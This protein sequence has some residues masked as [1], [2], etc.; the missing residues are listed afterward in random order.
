MMKLKHLLGAVAGT[1]LLASCGGMAGVPGTGAGVSPSS[2]PPVAT[3][4][5]NGSDIMITE[6]SH[7]VAASIGKRIVVFLRARPGMTNWSNISSSDVRVLAPAV[8][9]VMVPHGV[10]AAAFTAVGAGAALITASAGPLCPAAAPCP[11]YAALFSV[12][13]TV[14]KRSP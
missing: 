10:T 9:D 13:V 3:T 1:L 7:A 12:Q 6:Q 2:E 4:P 8:I 11:M 14:T 5:A